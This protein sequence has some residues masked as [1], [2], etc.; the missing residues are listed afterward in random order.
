M[1]EMVNKNWDSANRHYM[2]LQPC[3]VDKLS[4]FLP[5]LLKSFSPF[6]LFS[7]LCFCHPPNS[8]WRQDPGTKKDQNFHDLSIPNWLDY[9]AIYFST[10]FVDLSSITFILICLELKMCPRPLKVKQQR[11]QGYAVCD[12]GNFDWSQS[13]Q[14]LLSNSLSVLK[15][16]RVFFSESQC[17]SLCTVAQLSAVRLSPWRG[18]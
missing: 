17:V 16:Q 13:C 15:R 5:T 12:S 1:E 3:H 7:S 9:V 2:W 8:A 6:F 18:V 4:E 14:Q 10:E 11:V